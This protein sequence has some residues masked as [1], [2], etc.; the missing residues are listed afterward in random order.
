MK[1]TKYYSSI[2]LRFR[3]QDRFLYRFADRNELD[4][5]LAE[6]IERL[7]ACM[8]YFICSR[9]IISIIPGSFKKIG[10]Q[11]QFSLKYIIDGS[12]QTCVVKTPKGMIKDFGGKVE[13]SKYPH[14][15]ILNYDKEENLI[16]NILIA[17]YV[18]LLE[19]VPKI[20][21]EHEVLYIGKGTADCAIDRLNGHSSLERV[22]ADILRNDPSKEVAIILYN[23][24]MQ[25]DILQVPN[26]GAH[27]EIRGEKAKK[28]FKAINGFDPSINEQTEIVEA[29]LIDYFKTSIYNTHFT[30]GLSSKLKTLKNIYKLDFDAVVVE[31][32]NENIGNLVIFS[33]HSKPNYYHQA[34]LDIRKIEGRI[35][36]LD[37]N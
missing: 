8:I 6:L 14:N 9:P 32:N 35:S 25:K 2:L 37:L 29:L 12:E 23:F 24:R 30:N 33:Q 18:H 4:G 20:L 28:H 10:A 13:V 34:V 31:V 26:I 15:S 21:S 36:L 1:P 17:N 27:A 3:S 19:G 16:A 7:R 22:L 11:F 5:L